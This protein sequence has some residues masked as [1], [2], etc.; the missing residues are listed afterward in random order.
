MGA[1]HCHISSELAL[2]L[3]SEEKRRENEF[4]ALQDEIL[5]LMENHRLNHPNSV[6]IHFTVEIIGTHI[7][8]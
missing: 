2:L 5:N 6:R 4:W 3:Q 7:L 8:T 1:C